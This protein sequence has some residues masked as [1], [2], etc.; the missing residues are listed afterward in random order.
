MLKF[1]SFISNEV[2][3]LVQINYA[4]I[5]KRSI[6]QKIKFRLTNLPLY[7]YS[8]LMFFRILTTLELS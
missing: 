4:M 6:L 1:E 7:N 8:K 2:L 5:L 3:L